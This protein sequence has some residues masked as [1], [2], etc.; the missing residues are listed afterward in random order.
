M[1]CLAIFSEYMYYAE[2]FQNQIFPLALPKN[3]KRKISM[4]SFMAEM[5]LKY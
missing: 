2:W 4:K 1:K 3:L 5:F